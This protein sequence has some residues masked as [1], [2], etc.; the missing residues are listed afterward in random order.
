MSYEQIFSFFNSTISDN[1]IVIWGLNK[2]YSNGRYVRLSQGTLLVKTR[3]KLRKDYYFCYNISQQGE[4]AYGSVK[5]KNLSSRLRSYINVHYKTKNTNCS[6]F[7]HFLATGKLIECES[8]K[9]YLISKHVMTTYTGQ[10]ICVGDMLCV[11]YWSKTACSRKM[12]SALRK[13][14]LKSKKEKCRYNSL[15]IKRFRKHIVYTAE[16]IKGLYTDLPIK[17]FHFFV[18]V[19]VQNNIPIFAHQL[20][21]NMIDN[22]ENSPIIFTKGAYD[23]Y[24]EKDT[25]PAFIFI[26]RAKNR[27]IAS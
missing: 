9:N 19:D 6:T 16:E 18:C 14:F 3:E 8:D 12:P 23:P 11:M 4:S 10:K 7:A 1:E 22:C 5:D 2:A 26:N 27:K 13:N 20:G 17:D 24:R 21:K 15:F 25:S